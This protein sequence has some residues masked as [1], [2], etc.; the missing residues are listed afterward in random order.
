MGADR[1]KRPANRF[2]AGGYHQAIMTARRPWAGNILING[3]VSPNFTRRYRLDARAR[4]ASF[5]YARQPKQRFRGGSNS[6]FEG[7]AYYVYALLEPCLS[8]LGDSVPRRQRAD[9]SKMMDM[10]LASAP[11]DLATLEFRPAS[12]AASTT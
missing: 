7:F 3:A 11:V 2:A 9:E 8:V 6:A 1:K 12:R 5:R 4:T 10:R